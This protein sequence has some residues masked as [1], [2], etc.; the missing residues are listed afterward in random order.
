[1]QPNYP[2]SELD[3]ID[4]T[5]RMYV[6]PKI[7][8]NRT[9]LQAHK[10]DI[11]TNTAQLIAASGITRAQLASQKQFAEHLESLNIT[12]PTKVTMNE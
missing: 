2:Q 3:L 10:D 7:F 12:V 5:C 4:L 11:A 8:L 9:L 1:M 6:E